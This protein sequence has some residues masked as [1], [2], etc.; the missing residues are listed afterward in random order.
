MARE[1][2]STTFLGP[3][4]VN[5]SSTS[6][7]A[8]FPAMSLR[9]SAPQPCGFTCLGM[10][11][12]RASPAELE[13]MRMLVRQAMEEGA[14]GVGSSLIYAPAFY[15]DTAE[16]IELCKVAAEYNGMYISHIRS[17]GNQLLEAVDELIRIAREAKLPAE[18]YHLKAAGQANWSK[19]AKVIEM[20]EA[21]RA[22]G[23][24]I[25]A[26]MYMYTAGAT[27]L[28]GSMPPWVQ[29]GGLQQWIARMRDPAT[30][31]RLA[32]EMRTPTD[33][34]ENLL[35]AAGSPERVLF[36]GFKNPALK[37]LTGKTLAEVAARRKTT[38]EEAAMDLVIEDDSRVDTVY[39][40]MDEEDVKRNI[41]IPWVS[42]GSDAPSDSPE[43]VFLLAATHPRTYGNVA[44]LL[45]KYVRDEHVISAAEAVRKLTSLPAENLGLRDRGLLKP[46]F[47][48]DVAVFDP[49]RIQDHAT[50]AEPHQFATGMVH[51]FVNGTQ[52]LAGGEH[53]G[54]KPGRAV[55]GRGRKPR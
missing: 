45:G 38:P 17:E 1:T 7:V 2:S 3:R 18:I 16:L 30:R 48:A 9:L 41:T 5:T 35:L 36:V 32:E 31:R 40:M 24:R 19:R 28:N 52:V 54:A 21:A 43:G 22:Q 23:L 44:R 25:T 42:F 27:G 53:T 6:P 37:N 33:K 4:S 14:L 46:D 10:D 39:F 26:D 13:Q 47:V 8:A 15:A 34:W 29:E 20:V 55:W 12:R 11:D 51:V 50:Y 49:A